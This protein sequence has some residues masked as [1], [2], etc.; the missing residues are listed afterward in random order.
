MTLGAVLLAGGAGSRL[1]GVDKAALRL[2]GTTLLDRALAA[3]TG[4]DVVVVGPP[5]PLPGL[6]VVREDPPRSGPASRAGG[7]ACASPGPRVRLPAGWCSPPGGS[8]SGFA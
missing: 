5:R 8:R 1:G 7:P 6:R 4:L 2:D 3:L